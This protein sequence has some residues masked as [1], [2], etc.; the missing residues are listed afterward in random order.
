MKECF[1]VI[2]L[3][4]ERFFQGEG[5]ATAKHFKLQNQQ[6]KAKWQCF[7]PGSLA[8]AIKPYLPIA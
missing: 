4:L 1:G 2:L 3:A 8:I 5:G 7:V 6:A